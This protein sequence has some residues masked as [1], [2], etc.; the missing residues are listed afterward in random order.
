M[1][2]LSEERLVRLEELT[3]HQAET[4]EDLSGQVARQ[5][6]LIERLKRQLDDMT[7][8]FETLEDTAIAQAPTQ[9]PP[10]W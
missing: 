8:R 5:W 3:A 9:K 6:A 1:S 4:I 2:T 7:D 10:H